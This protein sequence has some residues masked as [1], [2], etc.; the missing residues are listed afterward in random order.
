LDLAANQ[1]SA[2]S[3]ELAK[4]R[5]VRFAIQG[6]LNPKHPELSGII[7]LASRLGRRRAIFGIRDQ[8]LL[9]GPSVSSSH[10]LINRRKRGFSRT[11]RINA[12]HS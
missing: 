6:L 5:Y 8:S 4:Y 1:A 10:S 7:L 12:D 3:D 2:T 9:T 11:P